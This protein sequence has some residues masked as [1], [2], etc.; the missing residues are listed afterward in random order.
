MFDPSPLVPLDTDALPP[1]DPWWDLYMPATFG[2]VAGV[3]NAVEAAEDGLPP[4][5]RGDVYAVASRAFSLLGRPVEAARFAQRAEGI[6]GPEADALATF[7]SPDGLER[8]EQRLTAGGRPGQRA[9]AG[10]DLAGRLVTLGRVPEARAAIARA[11]LACPS[12]GEAERWSR[13]LSSDADPL[14]LVRAALDPRR[15]RVV[16]ASASCTAAQMDAIELVAVRRTGWLSTERYSR[17]VLGTPSL[18]TWAP[19]GSALGRLQDVGVSTYF[20]ALEHE[21]AR[22][23]ANHLLV[24]CEIAADN[25]RSQLSEGRDVRALA[26]TFWASLARVDGEAMDDGAQLLAALATADARLAPLGLDAVAWLADRQPGRRSLWMG[27]QAWLTHLS[28]GAGATERAVTVTLQR[29]LDPLAWRLALEVFRARGEGA[30]VERAVC[31][32]RAEPRLAQ[33]ARE[34]G[35][36][37]EPGAF[38]TVVSGRLTPRY[39][40]SDAQMYG[41]GHASLRSAS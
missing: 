5:A 30:Q 20:F 37:Q 33:A 31:A 8:A 40:R 39:P 6:G 11:L 17:R 1:I 22:H 24:A 32:A 28:G 18:S 14:E 2:D 4:A 29:P 27:Y 7:L 26:E 15:A 35:L 36:D 16:A 13:F 38:R 41:S 23:P 12:H 10:C 34:V 19:A 21:H 9:D 3:L 25:L